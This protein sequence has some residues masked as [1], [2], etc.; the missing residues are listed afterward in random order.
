[1]PTREERVQALEKE[2][3]ERK[4]S[5]E[6]LTIAVRALVSKEAFE[7]LQETIERY[8]EQNGKLF[9]VIINQ[10]TLHNERLTDLQGQIIDVNGKLDGKVTVLDGKITT[11]H[12]ETRQ[13]FTEVRKDITDLK[14]DVSN[15]KSMAQQ[16][17][18]RLPEKP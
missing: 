14:T 18:A 11:L 13:Q 5:E 10:N 3:A 1:M 4:H 9:N 17:L 15:L 8:Q 2:L 12:T 7:K 16:I 6:M